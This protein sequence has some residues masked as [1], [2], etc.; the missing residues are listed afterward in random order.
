MSTHK[1]SIGTRNESNLHRSLKFRYTGSDGFTE[2][3]TGEFVADGRKADGEYIEVQTGS[4]APLEKKIRELSKKSKVR[5]IHPIAVKKTIEVYESIEK[6][7]KN[8]GLRYGKLLYRRKS[9][10]KGNK[11]NIFDALVYAPTL[12]LLRRVS[13]EI[14]FV[15]II[16]K[17]IKDGKGSWR[18]K[19]ISIADRELAA[20]RDSILFKRPKDF[21]TFLP[22]KK[23]EEFTGAALAKRSCIDIASA[24]K[25]LYV[26]T[27]MN[28]VKRI[29]K[30]GNSW[31]YVVS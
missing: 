31:K 7:K 10:V 26:L 3:E 21:L 16:E 6:K 22:F 19:G 13:I 23:N 18:R 11:W 27:K 29:G 28:V 30:Q 12:P 4:F 24:R 14:V 17:R 8:A 15:E 20:W 25:A 9:P 1:K 2:V 5:I